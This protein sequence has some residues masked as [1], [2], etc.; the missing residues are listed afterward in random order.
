MLSYSEWQALNEAAGTLGGLPGAWVKKLV[1]LGGGENSALTTS[2]KVA[3][4]SRQVTTLLYEALKDAEDGEGTIAV[5]IFAENKP[6][7][8]VYTSW[9]GQGVR[10]QFQAIPA[11][12]GLHTIRDTR[13]TTEFVY[14]SDGKARRR[15]SIAWYDRRDH[16]KG[17]LAQSLTGAIEN[18][19]IIAD[20]AIELRSFKIDKNRKQVAASR[21]ESKPSYMDP[22]KQNTDLRDIEKKVIMDK[23]KA[24]AVHEAAGPLQDLLDD[25]TAY[26]GGAKI[27]AKNTIIQALDGHVLNLPHLDEAKLKRA[28]EAIKKIGHFLD[29]LR[30]GRYGLAQNA[31]DRASYVGSKTSSYLSDRRP[32]AEIDNLIKYYLK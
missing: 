12:G 8:L 19:G 27:D 16:G 2:S 6:L 17:E 13:K 3:K 25:V 22:S 18:L 24:H 4:T 29:G 28:M 14:G 21:R 11:D 23:V 15:P 30:P 31:R 9:A 26:T 5:G 20:T 10:T 7:W 32:E 1:A